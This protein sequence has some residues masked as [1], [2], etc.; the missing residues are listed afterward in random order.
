M[1]KQRIILIHNWEN[2]ECTIK[3]KLK[4]VFNEFKDFKFVTNLILKLNE[5]GNKSRNESETN[6]STFQLNWKTEAIIH[7]SVSNNVFWAIYST[8]MTKIR[9]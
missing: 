8:I 6:Y 3:N 1:F 4:H 2:I 9:I 7:A 5:N